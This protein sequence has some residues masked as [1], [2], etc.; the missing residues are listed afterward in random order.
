M[1]YPSEIALPYKR[2]L[3]FILNVLLYEW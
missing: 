2:I 3:F 1:G